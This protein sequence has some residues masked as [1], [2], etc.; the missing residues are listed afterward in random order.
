MA[1]KYIQHFLDQAAGKIPKNQ[2]FYIVDPDG[3][4]KA[5]DII[6]GFR[7]QALNEQ[8]PQSSNEQKP[9]RKIKITK[10]KTNG[11]NE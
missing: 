1:N 7:E 2:Q 3:G 11:H 4:V 9:K 10:T 6:E 5:K 8:K